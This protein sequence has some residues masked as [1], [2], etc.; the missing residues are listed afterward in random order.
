MKEQYMLVA[1]LMRLYLTKTNAFMKLKLH[2]KHKRI[3]RES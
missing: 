3:S 1:P 2:P